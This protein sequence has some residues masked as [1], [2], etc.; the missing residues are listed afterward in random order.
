VVELPLVVSG[1][2]PEQLV[3]H[4]LEDEVQEAGAAQA[5]PFQTCGAI[6]SVMVRSA[7]PTIP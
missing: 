6:Q 5:V 4:V 2:V 7:H 1:A 3:S